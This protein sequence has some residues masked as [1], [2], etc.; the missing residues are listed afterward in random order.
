[1]GNSI[2]SHTSSLPSKTKEY[3]H[4]QNSDDDDDDPYEDIEEIRRNIANKMPKSSP[5]LTKN[6]PEPPPRNSILKPES[7]Y[8]NHEKLAKENIYSD[9]DTS[10]DSIK[11]DAEK[12]KNLM[13]DIMIS[14]DDVLSED[15]SENEYEVAE[16]VLRELGARPKTNNSRMTIDIR[17]KVS[18]WY[19]EAE[20]EVERDLSLDISMPEKKKNKRS[21]K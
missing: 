16:E 19:E 1:M 21:P 20:K 11:V 8:E 15:E 13:D 5:K 9:C 18:Q 3:L 12:N 2:D 10:G 6:A 17:S 7:I 14:E 4:F